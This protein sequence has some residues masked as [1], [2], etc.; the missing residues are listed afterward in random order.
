MISKC[1]STSGSPRGCGK[2]HITGS[3]SESRVIL[4]C[5]SLGHTQNGYS[6]QHL[7]SQRAIIFSFLLLMEL[8]EPLE[9]VQKKK[10]SYV[11]GVC[12]TEFRESVEPREVGDM[13]KSLFAS[14]AKR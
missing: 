7:H 12:R 6:W 1:K 8:G 9:V 11:F 10:P 14:K 4:I 3:G 13:E 2:A 5:K